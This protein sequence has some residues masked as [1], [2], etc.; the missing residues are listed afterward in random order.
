MVG[1]TSTPEIAHAEPGESIEARLMIQR[2]LDLAEKISAGTSPNP[3]ALLCVRN[4]RLPSSTRLRYRERWI[5]NLIA[6]RHDY[7]APSILGMMKTAHALVIARQVDLSDAYMARNR[8]LGTALADTL[9]RI[10]PG[11][12][13]ISHYCSRRT[14][15]DAEL[16]AVE[17]YARA[18]G[19]V[20]IDGTEDYLAAMYC[21]CRRLDLRFRLPMEAAPKVISLA[22][23][24]MTACLPDSVPA[25]PEMQ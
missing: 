12:S 4:T 1:M 25:I 24:W 6:R 13:R 22:S 14:G 5:S 2:I 10:Q 21:I 11:V 17:F 7:A 16:L 18:L 19:R 9:H 23:D 20:H 3:T 8:R 15:S